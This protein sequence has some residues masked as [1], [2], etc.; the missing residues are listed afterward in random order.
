MNQNAPARVD[1]RPGNNYQRQQPQQVAKIDTLRADA[2]RTIREVP[3]EEVLYELMAENNWLNLSADQRLAGYKA[4]CDAIGLDPMTFPFEFIEFTPGK[5][6]LYPTRAATDQLRR[7]YGVS[8]KI[9]GEGYDKETQTLWAKAEATFPD[10]RTDEDVAHLFT[11]GKAGL[12]LANMK[13]KVI[14]KAKRRVTLS[15]IGLGQMAEA[16]DDYDEG[17]YIKKHDVDLNTGRLAAGEAREPVDIWRRLHGRMARRI[18]G[19]SS[20]DNHRML[21]CLSAAIFDMAGSLKLIG[22][23]RLNEILIIVDEAEP[24]ELAA[25]IAV[26]AERLGI[27]NP[28]PQASATDDAP[29]SRESVET[30]ENDL[31]V[32]DDAQRASDDDT[33]ATDAEFAD[34]E[35][36]DVFDRMPTRV[37]AR[38]EA[39]FGY[40]EPD[41]DVP[42]ADIETGEINA[43]ESR[44]L[45][46]LAVI[47]EA[48]TKR[49]LDDVSKQVEDAG[50]QDQR[51]NEALF[52]KYQQAGAAARRQGAN[53]APAQ[54]AFTATGAPGDDR[55]T[56]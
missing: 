44:T 55:F 36:S 21:R 10:G 51:I 23:T 35:S 13:M 14:T 17:R 16:G 25:M 4:R 43:A 15:A 11:Y 37:D 33:D 2:P 20:E 32:A 29:E 18:P 7:L 42:F 39:E 40:P 6:T 28:N 48:N 30:R 34:V 22:D 31:P 5:V 19:A 3:T 41:D 38:D 53:P 1:N 54:Q 8:V 24:D 56:N 50:I 12:D 52:A 26:G 27:P 45:D 47:A 9:T 49:K 46:F